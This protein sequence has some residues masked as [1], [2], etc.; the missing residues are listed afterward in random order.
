MN[1][2]PD[3]PGQHVS[4]I[5]LN[6][7]QQEIFN[8]QKVAAVL[9]D[10]GYACIKL[11]D[12]WKGADFLADHF[13]DD[14]T[15]R[16]QLKGCLTIDKKYLG[17]GI[18]MAFPIDGTWHLV[19][20]DQLVEII[21][22]NSNVGN[23]SSWRDKGLH[24]AQKPSFAMRELLEPFALRA[25]TPKPKASSASKGGGGA[26]SE[27]FVRIGRDVIGPMSQ[28]QAAVTAVVAAAE[29]DVVSMEQLQQ[30]V[31]AQALR[32]VSGVVSSREVWQAMAR[33]HGL[34]EGKVKQWAVDQPIYR[35]DRT[36]VVQTNVWS[37]QRIAKLAEGLEGLTDGAVEVTLD[38]PTD[39]GI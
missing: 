30:L 6:A 16:V 4:Y 27:C 11:S 18:H 5:E 1:E 12:D 37:K 35:E 2:A 23:T 38:S 15:L 25:A 21:I 14:H 24:F 17:K 19:D 22:D 33:E 8:F 31:G 29:V 9:A 7:K 36:W 26:K 32:S 28:T 20:H 34:D 39:E 3:K 10:Y 13:T